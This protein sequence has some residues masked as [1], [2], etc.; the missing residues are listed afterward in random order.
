MVERATENEAVL[1]DDVVPSHGTD[2][3]IALIKE[4]HANIKKSRTHLTE[5][6]Q[7]ARESYEFFAG[8]QWD[9]Q[10]VSK[11]REEDRPVVVFNRIPRVINAVAGLEVQNR[12]EVTYYPRTN[13]D[14]PKSDIL[15]DAARWVRDLCDAEDEESQAFK[16]CLMTGLGWIE[17]HL[18]YE[19]DPDGKILI[20]RID[21]LDMEYDPGASKRNLDDAAWVARVKYYDRKDF[22][23]IWPDAYDEL[24][25]DVDFTD[26]PQGMQPHDDTM[27]PWYINDQSDKNQKDRDHTIEVIQYQYWVR[28]VFYRVELPGGE[29]QE[30]DAKEFRKRREEI[31]MVASRY[32]RQYRKRYKQA[33]IAGNVMLDKG[34]CP[35]NQFTFRSITG[36]TDHHNNVWFGLIEIMK[37]PQRWANKWL[38]QIMHILNSNAKGG[39]FAEIGAFQDPRQAEQSLATTSI[40]YVNEDMLEKIKD[41]VAPGFPVGLDK[42]LQYAVT[43]I[44]ELVGVNLEML[45]QTNREQSGVLELQRKQ[46]GITVVADFF[47]SLRRYRKEQGRVLA[48]FIR[49]YISD[50]RLVRVVGEGLGQY[51]PLTKMPDNMQYD[52]VVDESPTSPNQR[53]LVFDRLVTLFP[54]LQSSDIPIPEAVLDYA[55]LPSQLIAAWKQEIEEAKQPNPVAQQVEELRLRLAAAETALKEQEVANKQADT[56]EKQTKSALNIAKSE[57]EE[58]LTELET[59]GGAVDRVKGIME[60]LT[61]KGT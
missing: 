53:Q 3:D 38:S 42:L 15:N 49:E 24:D 37:D 35:V 43:G 10:D 31:L 16:D 44:N 25:A 29:I 5:W 57:H 60:A 14:L 46:A 6:K 52:I 51:V 47:D 54:L 1:Q 21:P 39:Y 34:D 18:D 28:E 50:G 56:T 32:T 61:P 45:G 22:K 26:H 17:T 4:I 12:Q 59:K 40:T 36:L 13:D 27:A 33:F 23:E 41:K 48:E 55:P 30:F 19:D 11:L 58:A 2:S 9:S 7:N 8:Q 20:D